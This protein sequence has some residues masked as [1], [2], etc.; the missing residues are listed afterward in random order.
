MRRRSFL[1]AVTVGAPLALSASLAT[2]QTDAPENWSIG[3]KG[4][5]KQ[6]VTQGVFG[7]GSGANLEL[8]CREAARLGIK[9]YDFFDDPTDWPLL[10]KYGLVLSMYRLDYPRWKDGAAGRGAMPA[11][12]GR[13]RGS[14]GAPAAAPA[15]EANGRGPT[16]PPARGGRGPMSPPGWDAIGQKEAAGEFMAAVHTAIDMAAAND[17]PNI[18][19]LAGNRVPGLSDEAGADNAVAFCN[20]VKSHAEDKG[21]TLCVELISSKGGPGSYMFDHFPWGA[22]VIKR[23]NS[24]R[25]KILF[26]IYHAQVMEGDIV[27]TIRDNIQLIGHFH[28]GGVPGRHE[29]DDTQELNWRFI[30]Q[31]IVDLGYT[32]FVTH[33]WTPAPGNDPIASL[34]K[35]MGIIDV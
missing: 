22:D 28:T 19:L 21:V 7:R 2:A 13:G 27:Q 23:V 26:D 17:V 32:G 3:R 33:E 4:R 16:T 8:C 11:F 12:A 29:L 24:P 9:G 18:I 5:I 35:V 25:V 31:T 34:N 30:A 15:G 14:N 6:G 1:S 10:K 20:Q